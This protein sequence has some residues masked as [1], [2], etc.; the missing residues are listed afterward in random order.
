M[1]QY[2]GIESTSEEITRLK[3]A[4]FIVDDLQVGHRKLTQVTLAC[5][6]LTA[7]QLK[8]APQMEGIA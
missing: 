6:V 4:L 3:S 5:R 7:G 1:K 2:E 8:S